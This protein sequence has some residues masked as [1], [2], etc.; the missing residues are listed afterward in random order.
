MA[1]MLHKDLEFHVD[2]PKGGVSP[3]FITRHYDK[4]AQEAISRSVASGGVIVHLDVVAWSPAAARAWGGD[5][6]YELAKE[7]PELSVLDR[8]VIRAESQGYVR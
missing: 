3:V 1:R 6:A 2:H 5:E 7:D 4:A 8:L